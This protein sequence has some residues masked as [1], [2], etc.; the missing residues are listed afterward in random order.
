[1]DS[2]ILTAERGKKEDQSGRHRAFWS[3]SSN[4][5][6]WPPEKYLS[7]IAPQSQCPRCN[8]G[9]VVPLWAWSKLD[10]RQDSLPDKLTLLMRFQA[11]AAVSCFQRNQD[12]S[13]KAMRLCFELRLHLHL[14]RVVTLPIDR[15][16]GGAPNHRCAPRQEIVKEGFKKRGRMD[17]KA[18]SRGKCAER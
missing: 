7:S 14:L 18:H 2:N 12:L 15:N 13:S 8:R 3:A 5:V 11:A 9:A 17:S 4:S 10:R 16:S 1:M 6:S